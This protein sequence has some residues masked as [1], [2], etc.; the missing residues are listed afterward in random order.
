MTAGVDTSFEYHSDTP[1]GKDP[2]RYSPTLRRHHQLLW[3][4][5]LPS[6]EFFDLAPEPKSY[7]AHRSHLGE[8][9]LSS[10][11]ITT[12]LQKQA[13]S[14]ISSIP[15]DDIPPYRGYTAGSALVFPG[16]QIGGQQVINQARGC[17]PLIADRFDLTLECI[18]RHYLGVEPNPLSDALNRYKDF[19]ALFN[20]FD[21]YVKFFLLQDLVEEDGVTIKY[22]H[23]FK[24]F[25]TPAVQQDKDQYLDYLRRKNNFITARN[26]T[27]D[28]QP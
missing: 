10:D 20:T 25:T 8:F 9:R 16:I 7:L 21:G 15:K 27:I 6:G 24:N 26:A 14:L 19:F 1:P 17:H 4:K 28:A 23:D 22:F 11:A 3:S 2:D 12:R 13:A 18:R 5:E